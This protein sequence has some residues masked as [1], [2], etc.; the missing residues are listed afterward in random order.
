MPPSHSSLFQQCGRQVHHTWLPRPGPLWSG[1][2]R[3]NAII[4]L[5]TNATRHWSERLCDEVRGVFESGQ[6]L[7]ATGGLYEG[8]AIRK[9]VSGASVDGSEDS[10]ICTFEL[11]LSLLSAPYQSTCSNS[12]CSSG[13]VTVST[14][15]RELRIGYECGQWDFG[16]VAGIADLCRPGSAVHVVEVSL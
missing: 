11:V 3:G 9:S 2:V 5:I 4:R 14:V 12:P 8:I 10:R 7:R 1:R 13:N 16:S 15:S 6:G